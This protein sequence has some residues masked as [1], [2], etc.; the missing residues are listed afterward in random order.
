MFWKSH[1]LDHDDTNFYDKKYTLG[2]DEFGFPAIALTNK[3]LI[4]QHDFGNNREQLAENWQE[5]LDLNPFDGKVAE[6]LVKIY[7]GKISSL[8][9]DK[10]AAEIHRI[11]RKLKLAQGRA[12]RYA[13]AH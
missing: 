3:L 12:D 10:D 2:L 11:H 1:R 5:W 6:K 13:F 9:P 7:H 4:A 8:D